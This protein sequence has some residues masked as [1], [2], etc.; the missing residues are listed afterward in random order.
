MLA[1][2][3]TFRDT[4]ST[5]N[6]AK[7]ARAQPDAFSSATAVSEETAEDH[8]DRSWCCIGRVSGAGGGAWPGAAGEVG[9][10]LSVLRVVQVV[11]RG[12]PPHDGVYLFA[13]VSAPNSEA[14]WRCMRLL[15]FRGTRVNL[16]PIAICQMLSPNVRTCDV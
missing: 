3:S 6:D 7:L 12:L 9:R 15:C 2:T 16:A 13:I 8:C 10:L 11:K 14:Y 1:G 5:G 4:A